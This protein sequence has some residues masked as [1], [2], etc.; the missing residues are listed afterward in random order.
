MTPTPAP[1]TLYLTGA[2]ATGKTEVAV[3]LA[4][5]LGGEVV[6]MDSMT[7]YR[8]LDVGTAKPSEAERRGVPHHLIDVLDPWDG[9]SV[10]DYLAWAHASAREI[11]SRGR[12]VLVVGGT[13]LYLKAMLRGLFQGPS[14][15]PELRRGLEAEAE[16]LG[17]RALHDRLAA[18]DP[19][20]AARLHP[21]DLRRVVRAIEV[22]ERTGRPISQFQDEHDQPAVGARVVA[23]SRPRPE[24]HERI[25]RRASAMFASG[26]VEEARR[27]SEAERPLNPVPAQAAG[28]REALDWIAGRIDRDEAIAR[29]SART[30]QLAKRQETW[31][32][33]LVEVQPC[34]V[35]RDEP[36]RSVAGRIADWLEG[37]AQAA[38][39]APVGIC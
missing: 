11:A 32:R 13:P 25:D 4:R 12:A 38:L 28:Y 30:R 21:N 3:E 22:F 37:D 33:G 17:G 14:A 34:P 27:L 8:G 23:L 7:L 9:A 36:A 29:T 35:G 10:A 31:F 16:R 15:D 5:R 24:L 2:T 6:A 20:A 39:P 18:V 26:L 19:V 1:A